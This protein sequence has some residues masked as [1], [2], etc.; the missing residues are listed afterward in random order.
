MIHQRGA[1]G[2]LEKVVMPTEMT[3][4]QDSSLEQDQERV[5]LPMA[6]SALG[7]SSQQTKEALKIKELNETLKA[8]NEK[9]NHILRNQ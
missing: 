1:G 7:P 4:D 5:F 3:V 2:N 8:S 9:V 6:L